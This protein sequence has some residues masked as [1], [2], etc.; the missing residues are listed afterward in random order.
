MKAYLDLLSHVMRH[1]DDVPGRNGMVRK[2]FAPPPFVWDLRDGIPA[3]TTKRIFS[4]VVFA[5]LVV[6]LQGKCTL[7][8][9]IE[10]GCN[11]WTANA[12]AFGG[13]TGR[14]YGV[15]WRHWRTPDGQEVDQLA[16]LIDSLRNNPQDR[17]M[18]VSAWNPGELM[19]MCLPPCHVLFQVD[20]SADNQGISLC[21]FQRSVD[22]FLGLP[23][24]ILSYATLLAL[25][26]HISGREANRLV[27][28]LG[29]AH[30]YHQHFAQVQEQLERTPGTLP[31][32]QIN[33][34]I[35][36]LADIDEYLTPNDFRLVGYSPQPYIRA[37][38]TV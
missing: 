12:Q 15:Q 2:S 29:N 20:V 10:A 36:T 35:Q 7:D 3:L 23:F 9:F 37:A 6:F 19:E 31:H 30:I 4:R 24:N 27:I 1:G 28:Y 17:R 13:E 11:I 32:M 8:D 16:Q 25:L 26:A 22:M 18:V 21:M 38:M 33:P 5:E 34:A 14:I